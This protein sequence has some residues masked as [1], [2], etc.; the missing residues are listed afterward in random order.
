MYVYSL[1]DP[2]GHPLLAAIAKRSYRVHR[3]TCFA[4][5]TS[6]AIV[7]DPRHAPSENP[8]ASE[9][10]LE[11]TDLFAPL[12]PS[13][14]VLVRG[15][16]HSRRRAVPFLDTAVVAGSMRKNVR[17]WGHR[18]IQMDHVNRL[19]FTAPEPFESV[20][21]TWDLAYGGRDTRAE[22]QRTAGRR[23]DQDP[24]GSA[25]GE[26]VYP[27][28]PAGRG[29]FLDRDRE[30]LAGLPAP[31]LEDPEDPVSPDR[32]LARDP[33]DWLDRPMAACYGPV[34]WTCFPR[35]A[36]WIGSDAGP[37]RGPFR[38]SAAGCSAPTT[39][40]CDH[41]A[42]RRIFG[43]TTVLPPDSRGLDFGETNA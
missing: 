12:K 16:A 15:C 14:D 32:L 39:F 24:S 6:P 2:S 20:R 13:T 26:I 1:H 38:R 19:R 11:D 10:L 3:G 28:N 31:R 8:G 27:R 40:V 34:D 35:S 41:P 23:N 21:L 43:L 5:P 4:E 22:Q 25:G 36:F 33:D 17:V 9:L 29:F 18:T 30:S 42:L 37:P 7:V